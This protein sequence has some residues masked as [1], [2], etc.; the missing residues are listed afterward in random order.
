MKLPKIIRQWIFNRS[1]TA[2]YPLTIQRNEATLLHRDFVNEMFVQRN[3]DFDAEYN[4]TDMP[5][6]K[7]RDDVSEWMNNHDS[8]YKVELRLPAVFSE[9]QNDTMTI[10][11]LEE[12]DRLEFKLTFL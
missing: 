7:W 8:I 2:G 6:F 3:I 1:K 5:E 12:Q 9:K 11:F 10:T 4:L